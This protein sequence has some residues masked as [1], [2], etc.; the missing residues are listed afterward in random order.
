MAADTVKF[1]GKIPS[2][3]RTPSSFP[4]FQNIQWEFPTAGRPWY[5]RRPARRRTCPA[6]GTSVGGVAPAPRPGIEVEVGIATGA[7]LRLRLGI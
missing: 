2:S 1:G 6:A 5:V 4:D 3:L 7:G